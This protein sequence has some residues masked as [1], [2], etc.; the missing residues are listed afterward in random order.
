MRCKQCES[1]LW[2]Q[3]P[4]VGGGDR[5]CS[6]CGT[7]YKP[8]DFDFV[9]GKVRFCCPHCD[10][11]YYGTSPRGH[12]EPIAFECPSCRHFIHMDDCVLR[13]DGVA[14][15]SKAVVQRGIPWLEGGNPLSR[16][17][18]TVLLGVTEPHKFAARLPGQT[19]VLAA[20]SFLTVQ[21]WICMSPFICCC[22]L[23]GG[24][25][26]AAGGGGGPPFLEFLSMA[27]SIVIGAPLAAI[28][29]T[30]LAVVGA[31]LV[32]SENAPPFSRDVEMACY[33]S[34]PLLIAAVPMYG[35]P[36]VAWWF[37]AAAIAIANARPEGTR[38]LVGIATVVGFCVPIGVGIVIL[39]LS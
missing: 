38:M 15:E 7:A 1:I 16:W 31:R 3:P 35:L 9:R 14:D 8:S 2:Q 32:S 23:V 26:A 33:S 20:L 21:S 17:F 10:T 37:I 36:I 24:I 19:R 13:P 27:G 11:G 4:A 39:L 28:V 6:E 18:G 34:G 30:L 22:G 12:L 29:L 25:S 5:C